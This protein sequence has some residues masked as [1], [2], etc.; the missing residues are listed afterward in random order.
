MWTMQLFGN[1]SRALFSTFISIMTIYEILNMQIYAINQLMQISLQIYPS[2]QGKVMSF[3][4]I[5]F[6]SFRF[7]VFIYFQFIRAK[8]FRTFNL[9]YKLNSINHYTRSKY[10]K[11]YVTKKMQR[12]RQR[13]FSPYFLK[14]DEKG[15]TKKCLYDK[16]IHEI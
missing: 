14:K 2:I 12:F 7:I 5:P 1:Y 4:V 9:W 11:H 15:K 6:R 10:N 8:L 16:W 13:C 3:L